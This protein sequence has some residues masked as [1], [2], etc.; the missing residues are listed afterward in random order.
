MSERCPKCG[1][2]AIVAHRAG[3]TTWWRCPDSSCKQLTWGTTPPVH[4]HTRTF[5]GTQ[6]PEGRTRRL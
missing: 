6:P 3:R 5:T 1:Q 2:P 4:T